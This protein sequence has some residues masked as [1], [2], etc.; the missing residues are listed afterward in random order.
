MSNITDEEYSSLS[1]SGKNPQDLF[2][3]YMREYEETGIPP[4]AFCSEC[5]EEA[6]Y[7]PAELERIMNENA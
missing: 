7:A 6:E 2:G 5:I 3:H 1:E 4:E